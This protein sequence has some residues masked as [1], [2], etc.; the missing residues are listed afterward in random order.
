MKFLGAPYPITKHPRGLLRTQE[1]INQVKS[2]LL[3][4]LLTNP[5][6]RCM[7]PEFGTPLNE[8]IFEPND[9][10]I[11]Q[12]ATEMIAESI[13]L[14]EPRIA[15]QDIDI[16][17]DL[18]VIEDSL[19]PVDLKQDMGHILLIKIRFSDFDNVQE[20]QQLELRV[21]IAGG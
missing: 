13:R 18:D 10:T 19:N 20:I 2:D 17:T 14:W 1:G 6:E 8:L 16:T 4:L 21:P 9:S 11:I 15:I 3:V 5:G 7:L 12:T